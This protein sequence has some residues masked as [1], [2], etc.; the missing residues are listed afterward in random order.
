MLLLIQHLTSFLLPP[1][2]CGS[3]LYSGLCSDL[4]LDSIC[5]GQIT[6]NTIYCLVLFK[7]FQF[8]Y[9]LK[10]LFSELKENKNTPPVSLRS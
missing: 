2:V 6:N 7:S 4:M 3:D 1:T 9:M 5:S 8:E 10:S